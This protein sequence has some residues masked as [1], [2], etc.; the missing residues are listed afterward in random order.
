M[1]NLVAMGRTLSRR[2]AFPVTA[3]MDFLTPDILNECGHAVP[4]GSRSPKDPFG[5]DCG[6]TLIRS[7]TTMKSTSP[8]KFMHKIIG[9]PLRPKSENP[10]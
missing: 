10:A 7:P 6:T 9:C 4:R 8:T 3:T 2:H 5:P 1:R